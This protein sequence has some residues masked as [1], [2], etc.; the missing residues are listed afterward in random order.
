MFK[1]STKLSPFKFFSLFKFCLGFRGCPNILFGNEVI[2]SYPI[3][4]IFVKNRILLIFQGKKHHFFDTKTYFQSQISAYFKSFFFLQADGFLSIEA[5][6]RCI[7]MGI[8]AR[9]AR[10]FIFFSN[11]SRTRLQN[12]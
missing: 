5:R 2:H 7:F 11:N 4:F 6:F 1:I 8:I 12:K 9:F 10:F 3:L